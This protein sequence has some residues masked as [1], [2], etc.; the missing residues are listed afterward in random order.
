MNTEH[1]HDLMPDA[2]IPDDAINHL[3]DAEVRKKWPRD[4]VAIIDLL[5]A[6]L[7]RMG[8]SEDEAHR[9]TYAMVMEQAAYCGGRYFYLPKGDVLERAIRDKAL[10]KD[11]SD[12]GILPNELAQK[13]RITVQHVYRVIKEQRAYHQAKVQPSL[14]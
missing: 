14:F 7:R 1:Q 10:Y 12:H 8:Y 5:N 2:P 4:L 11:W 13:Y 9:I 3:E 6:K